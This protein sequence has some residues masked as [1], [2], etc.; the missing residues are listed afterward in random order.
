MRFVDTNVFLRLILWD[1]PQKAK[2]CEQLFLD[3][4]LRKKRLCTSSLVIAKIIWVLE[5]QYRYPRRQIS[6]V[7]LN[8]INTPELEITDKDL[9]MVAVGLYQMSKIDFIDAYNAM[10]MEQGRVLEIYSYDDH[11]DAIKSV[12]RLVP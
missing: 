11:F 4:L 8:I 2:R 1:D 10:L 7:V 6:D 9:L 3:A 5:R 12:K